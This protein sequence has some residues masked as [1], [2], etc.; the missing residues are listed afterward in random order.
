MIDAVRHSAASSVRG[1]R[2]RNRF[3]RL[4]E[5]IFEHARRKLGP[6]KFRPAGFTPAAGTGTGARMGVDQPSLRAGKLQH[7]RSAV[8]R[9][10]REYL[11]ADTKGRPAKMILLGDG[12]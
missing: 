5:Q 1:A 12:R 10:L 2:G 7:G 3:P 11:S 8:L 4:R 6:A 9:E